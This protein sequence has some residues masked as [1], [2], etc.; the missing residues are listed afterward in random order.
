VGG[1]QRRGDAGDMHVGRCAGR[2][3]AAGGIRGEPGVGDIRSGGQ[4]GHASPLRPPLRGGC[5]FFYKG[6][7]RPPLNPKGDMRPP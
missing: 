6:D 7:M 4:V 1:V 2:L 5:L 3:L